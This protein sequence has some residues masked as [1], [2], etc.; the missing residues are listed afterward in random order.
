MLG[1]GI[2]I[3]S[4]MSSS[5]LP[6]KAGLSMPSGRCC[7]QEVVHR[8]EQYLTDRSIQIPIIVACPSED[9]SIYEKLIENT[10]A[11]LFG[12][13][14]DNVASRFLGACVENK[15]EKVIR[16]TGDNPFVCWDVLD[17]I[18]DIDKNEVD[19][20]LSLYSQK[21]LPNG[22]I[23]SSIGIKYLEQI[24]KLNCPLAHEHL[25]I[26][27]VEEINHNILT[28]NLPD[29]LIWP[30]GRF[31][32]DDLKDYYYIHKNPKLA[33]YFTV[34]EMKKNISKWDIIQRY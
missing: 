21:K 23:V 7:I 30:E 16:V 34:K 24:C 20:C 26:S 22:T 2:V 9:F 8:M 1:K 6:A 11:I 13:D 27:N 5:R 29:A 10:S 32:L 19:K 15:L 3:Q 33:E 4:R 28:P 25:V 17:F 12:G 18:F 14:R 31:C